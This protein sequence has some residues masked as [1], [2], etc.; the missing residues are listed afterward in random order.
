MSTSS[1][2]AGR[3]GRR[4]SIAAL[5][6]ALMVTMVAITVPAGSTPRAAF[7]ATA[8]A[9]A[10][11]T[12]R[13]LD[14]RAKGTPV[15]VPARV[16]AARANLARSLGHL[17][18][19][20]S[21]PTTGTLR[22]VG[23][24]D[25][26]LTNRSARTAASIALG[27]VRANRV[28]FGVRAADIRS[29]RLRKDYVD[30][31]GT[32]HLSWVQRANGLTLFGQGLRANVT[33]DGRLINIAGGPMRGLRAPRTTARLSAS[34]AIAAAR[35][36]AG[37]SSLA[38]GSRDTA[39]LALF[40]T[41][42]GARLAWQTITFVA[43]NETDMSFVDAS[44]GEVLY[45]RNL[46]S[47]G[48]PTSTATADT[49]PFYAS[50]IPPNGGGTLAPATFPVFDTNPVT[51]GATE[52]FGPNAWV[53][54]DVRDDSFPDPQDAVH[55]SSGLAFDYAPHLT[56]TPANQNCSAARQC[57]WDSRVA[58]SWRAN[59]KH[60]AVQV[61]WFLNQFHDHLASAPIGFNNGAGNFEFGGT[62]GS[63]PVLG[64]ASDG[65]NTD[66]GF[67]DLDHVDNANMTTFPDG[68]PPIMQMYLFRRL[69]RFGLPGIPS[70]NGGDDAEVVYHEYTHGLSNRLVVY[71]DGS[72]GLDN[73]Q[74][75][76]MGEAWSDWYAEDFL[77][78][79]GYK[80]DMPA[81]GDV[82]MGEL[83][84]AGEL[85]SQPVDCPVG[86]ASPACPG[87]FATGPGGYTYG[88]FGKITTFDGVNPAPEVHAD[89]EI[90]LETLW[91]L[92]QALPNPLVRNIVT[93]GMELSPPSPSY[94]DMRNAIIQGDLVETGGANETTIWQVF[95]NRGMGYF[96]SSVG[97]DDVAP[98]Q[99]F[100]TPPDCAIDPCHDVSGT[101][102]DRVTGDPLDGATVGFAGLNSGFGFDLSDT[103]AADGNYTIVDVPDHDAY[104]NFVFAATGYEPKVE[105]NLV[106]NGANVTV[107]KA[108]FRD[109][110]ALNAGAS[111]RSF[112][113]PDYID[114][115]GVNANGA[116]DLNLKSGWPSDAVGFN[117]SGVT[118]PRKA[119]VR[120]PTSVDISAIAVASG[121][122]CGDDATAAVKHFQLQ[123]RR[124]K[125]DPWKIAVDARAKNDGTLRTFRPTKASK[126][127]SAIRFVMLSNFGDPLFMDVLEVSV[128]GIART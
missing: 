52:L 112:T 40:P 117:G 79:Q 1:V 78:Q 20:S 58:K 70:A 7:R 71:P 114:F 108:L 104:A 75:G 39:K 99:D 28:A 69:P 23:R 106:V 32:H 62:G 55:P 3:L 93:R 124:S 36:S 118:G 121:G 119:V 92:R 24:L 105:S 102:T 100:S 59:L 16:S 17:G 8:T 12:Q 31:G 68:T 44:T 42:R 66:H 50:N 46:T 103:T 13:T 2:P 22:F 97:G 123:T 116:F 86:T 57:T 88:D 18:S 125:A 67:P 4:T 51:G 122:A 54:T 85:R 115:C 72:S 11:A 65:A 21:D 10:A 5:V 41:G 77:N 63:D 82:V 64:N 96:A 110:A 127:V 126:N 107:N 49:W 15:G 30:V 56:T 48:V 6:A 98:F 113:P 33:S 38:R 87:G 91:D 81:V 34:S 43:S 73:Q 27:Y 60:D 84:F 37:A 9:R 83:S 90:W 14:V 35:G 25:G 94:L 26:F 45:R 120:L 95:A 80:P 53:F 89:G 47:E 61:Y 111:L 101:V 29:L 74:A 76:S 109:W 19:I 128:R